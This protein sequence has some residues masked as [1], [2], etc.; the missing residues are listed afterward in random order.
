M[1]SEVTETLRAMQGLLDIDQKD[2]AKIAGVS[3][4]TISNWIKEKQNPGKFEWDKIIAYAAKH[5]KTAHLAHRY[6]IGLLGD[7]G[8]RG[9]FD[10]ALS[11]LKLPEPTAPSEPE[12]AP[13]EKPQKS[14]RTHRERK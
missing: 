11:A 5:A 8:L 2:L 14:P 12:Q 4:T 13:E 10:A 7:A 9:L 1:T 3:Q 6:V